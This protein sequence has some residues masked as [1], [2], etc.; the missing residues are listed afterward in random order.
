MAVDDESA[1]HSNTTTSKDA[2]KKAARSSKQDR[3]RVYRYVKQCGGA[4]DEQIC[5]ALDMPV[6]TENPRR[7]ELVVDYCVLRDSGRTGVTASG[8]ATKIWEVTSDVDPKVLDIPVKIARGTWPR[9]FDG[10]GKDVESATVSAGRFRIHVPLPIVRKAASLLE[11]QGESVG[12]LGQ[13]LREMG[14][15]MRRTPE[16]KVQDL[17]LAYDLWSGKVQADDFAFGGSEIDDEDDEGTSDP[18]DV[19]DLLGSILDD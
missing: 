7:D 3:K 8:N 19:D 15:H 1:P 5:N 11:E 9:T 12:R 16:E 18:V 17:Y 2:A 6:K 10:F 4:F 14:R 13:F